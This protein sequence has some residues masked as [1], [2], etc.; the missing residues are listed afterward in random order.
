MRGVYGKDMGV[1]IGKY[2]VDIRNFLE[3]CFKKSDL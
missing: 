3:K 2:L 1:V